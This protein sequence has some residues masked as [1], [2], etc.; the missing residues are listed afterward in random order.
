[1]L[2]AVE[3]AAELDRLLRG[4]R[5]R[6]AATRSAHALVGHFVG[7]GVAAGRLRRDLLRL[8]D[9]VLGGGVRRARHGV[10]GLA[11]GR[12][13]GP[14]QV[15]RRAAEDDVALVPGRADHFGGH[16]VHVERRVRAVVADA[17]LERDASVRLDD[18]QAVE[19]D[20]A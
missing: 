9:A 1:Q 14:R 8:L 18:E 11:A 10:R 16:A 15:L 2:V 3:L 5:E 7:V 20:R 19:A 6:H 13:A 17:R 12:D 4:L